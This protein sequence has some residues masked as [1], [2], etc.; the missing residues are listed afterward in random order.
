MIHWC[1][2]S[3][4]QNSLR[5]QNKFRL[6]VFQKN[7]LSKF[8]LLH[9]FIL[10]SQSKNS[11]SFDYNWPLLIKC[12]MLFSSCFPC[13]IIDWFTTWGKFFCNP[14]KGSNRGVSSLSWVWCKMILQ[15]E[16]EKKKSRAQSQEGDFP[17]YHS[18]SVSPLLPWPHPHLQPP[19]SPR[20]VCVVV[21]WTIK[22]AKTVYLLK[23]L[24]AD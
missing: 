9:L 4:F 2:Y 3:A 5:F 10:T 19:P 6:H 16:R 11:E 18:F 24:H 22:E 17:S 23:V 15:R 13:I 1:L 12:P 21:V 20:F 8:W 14:T 7:L